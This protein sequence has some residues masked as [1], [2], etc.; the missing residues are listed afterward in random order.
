MNRNPDIA[1]QR[2]LSFRRAHLHDLTGTDI[3]DYGT[4]TFASAS[5]YVALRDAGAA[6]CEYTL[7]FGQ[8]L[9]RRGLM[10]LLY[11]VAPYK[12]H[13]PDRFARVL[14]NW[15]IFDRARADRGSNNLF[16]QHVQALKAHWQVFGEHRELFMDVFKDTTETARIIPFL[17]WTRAPEGT[18]RWQFPAL[19]PD[20]DELT[21]IDPDLARIASQGKPTFDALA[22]LVVVAYLFPHIRAA[23]PQWQPL[24]K[25]GKSNYVGPASSAMIS[26]QHR[27]AL[28]NAPLVG[29]AEALAENA[30]D[31]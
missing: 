31:R 4:L 26:L 17:S 20:R 25:G 1:T 30:P 5:T 18:R 8:S 28:L 11:E 19:E 13:G 2:R 7:I 6:G 15:G 22:G 16:M 3:Q 29:R 12:A 10:D 24:V 9:G 27:R 14:D 23:W 21:A